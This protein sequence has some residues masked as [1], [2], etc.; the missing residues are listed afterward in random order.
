MHFHVIIADDTTLSD[1]ILV[2]WA[3]HTTRTYM[4]AL[5]MRGALRLRVMYLEVSI[6]GR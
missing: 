4:S 1:L 2:F 3:E 6:I 5:W